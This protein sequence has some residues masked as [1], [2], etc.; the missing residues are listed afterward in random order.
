MYDFSKRGHEEDTCILCRHSAH[1]IDIEKEP[2]TC[3]WF[4]CS[5]VGR[6]KVMDSTLCFQHSDDIRHMI[7]MGGRSIPRKGNN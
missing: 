5:N 3:D 4:T 7:Y 6:A 2:A 1:L